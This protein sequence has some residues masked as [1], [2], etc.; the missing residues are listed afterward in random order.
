M[1]SRPLPL[2]GLRASHPNRGAQRRELYFFTLYRCF[3]AALVVFFVF[4]PLGEEVVDLKHPGLARGVALSYLSLALLL[5]VVL[6]LEVDR[7]IFKD[8]SR[9]PPGGRHSHGV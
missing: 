2:K 1:P 6:L 5:L 4:S 8:P 7:P 3:Q 9:P